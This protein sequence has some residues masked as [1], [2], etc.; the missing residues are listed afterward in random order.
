MDFAIEEKEPSA[1]IPN[2]LI[3]EMVKGKPF[4]YKEYNFVQALNL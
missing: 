3:Y 2:Y 1:P 4:Y